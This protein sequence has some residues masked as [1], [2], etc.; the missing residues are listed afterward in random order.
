MKIAIVTPFLNYAG[1]V[2]TVNKILC[3]IFLENGHS[4]DF[5]TTDD[6]IPNNFLSKIKIKIIGLPYITSNKFKSLNKTYDIV[7]ANGEFGWGIQHK[8]CI[9]L[10][11]GSA[12]GYRNFLKKQHSLKTYLK[13]TF[14]S[15]IQ[16][17]SA[18]NKYVVS[19]SAFTKKV[20]NENGIKVNQVITN[21][22]NL[23]LFQNQKKQKTINYLFVGTYDYYGK[24]FDILESISENDSTVS[25]ITN[26]NPGEKLQWIKNISNE[27][28]PEIYNKT[29]ILVFPSRFEGLGLAPLEAM[30][31]GVP[32][33]ISDV[34]LGDELKNKIP[35]FVSD[36][37]NGQSYL[38]KIKKINSNYQ[39][40]S[41]LARDYV[42]N[43]HSF[44]DFKNNWLKLIQKLSN[45]MEN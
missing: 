40:Y 10:F 2:E 1:G 17:Q 24:G 26:S 29:H 18:K 33:V 28:M 38:K 9:N 19:V 6:Y 43:H 20:L 41:N 27:K 21:S 13:L 25:C 5:I 44:V 15:L 22:I 34:G 35:E 3:N 31:C 23:N 16:K 7:I 12:I 39:Y 37:F 14:Q 8:R 45:D 42:E 11:H 36:N 30:A 32:V 4:V